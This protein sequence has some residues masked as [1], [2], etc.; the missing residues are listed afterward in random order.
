MFVPSL[1]Q[2]TIAICCTWYSKMVPKN[3]STSP[4]SAPVVDAIRHQNVLIVDK[5][6]E[7]SRALDLRLG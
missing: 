3:W 2:Q 1:S 5:V 7:V 4:V 6:D